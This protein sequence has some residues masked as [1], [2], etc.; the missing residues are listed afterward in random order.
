MA[1]SIARLVAGVIWLDLSN[2]AIAV[3]LRHNHDISFA[4]TQC[5]TMALIYYITNYATKVEDLVWKRVVVAAEVIDA[6]GKPMPEAVRLEM[7]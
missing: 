1:K 6:G 7:I 4:A 3:G 5:N 2:K